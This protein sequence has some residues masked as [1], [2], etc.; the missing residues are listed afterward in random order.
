[1]TSTA[2]HQRCPVSFLLLLLLWSLSTV[3]REQWRVN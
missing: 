3:L 2:S 1:V